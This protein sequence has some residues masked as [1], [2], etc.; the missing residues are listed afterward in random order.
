MTHQKA[1]GLANA[2]IVGA[3]L[4]VA[5][6]ILGLPFIIA[7]WTAEPLELNKF[8]WLTGWVLVATCCLAIRVLLGKKLF[9]PTP[10][11]LLGFGIWISALT[12]SAIS[13]W[14]IPASFLGYSTQEYTSVIGAVVFFLFFS[15]ITVAAKT[16]VGRRAIM[17]SII[18]SSGLV[19]LLA[20]LSILGVGIGI[21]GLPT[22][23]PTVTGIF[24]I[25]T[26]LFTL[27]YI[28]LQ[29]TSFAPV[30]EQ[31]D[32]RLITL[33]G[34]ASF[35]IA[36]PFYLA[37]D[38]TVVWVVAL[39]CS[40][41]ILAAGFKSQSIRS[42]S[43]RFI[44]IALLILMSVSML[45]ASPRFFAAL[46]LEVGPNAAASF[47]IAKATWAD[48]RLLFG[49][50]PGTFAL[51]FDLHH[52]AGLNQTDF[53]DARFDRGF[54]HVATLLTTLGILGTIAWGIFV[55]CIVLAHLH[56]GKDGSFPATPALIAFLGSVI[57]ACLYPQT[58]TLAAT[59]I[60]FAGLGTALAPGSAQE[61]EMKDTAAVGA[62]SLVGGSVAIIAVL[63]LSVFTLS[64][65][66][67]EM[68]Y[69]KALTREGEASYDEAILLLDKA[70]SRNRWNDAY[71]AALSRVLLTK[72]DV[73]ARDPLSDPQVVQ[74]LLGSS[75]NA[76]VKATDLAP[77]SAVRWAERGDLYRDIAGVVT[78]GAPFSLVSY[79]EAIKFSPVNPKYRVGIGRAQ[80][81][82][83]ESLRQ[84]SEAPGGEQFITLR[85]E[86]LEAADVAFS[87]AIKL[88]ADYIPALYFQAVTLDA[89]GL[90]NEAVVAMEKV[91]DAAPTDIG[92][93][94]NLAL[95]Y[96]RQERSDLAKIELE[97]ALEI[98]PT[99]ANARWYL[100]IIAEE[101]GDIAGAIKE[102]E[103][104]LADDPQNAAAKQRLERLNAPAP[105]ETETVA[106]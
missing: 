20:T 5:I 47:N 15:A 12:I 85:A 80:L 63:F 73:I 101:A 40:I 60:V 91:R 18:V 95:L 14:S 28:A 6:A 66:S 36:I 42:L 89:R 46:P 39:L 92:V 30:L 68:L 23:T 102:V 86:A 26:H 83:A 67:A 31:A 61:K 59:M 55:I 51:A 45:V 19:S 100:S 84:K 96:M 41:G 17:W 29:G 53:W 52:N 103:L 33:A 99:F 69:A 24:L 34:V 71:Y 76:A 65:Y 32:R 106:Q 11:A 37:L 9:L 97:K 21:Q 88:K 94:L 27:S 13:S 22:G 38:A 10:L 105:V 64:R 1:T 104:I 70:A 7:P 82:I 49:S 48:G 16:I 77:T 87:Q 93:R 72:A 43:V 58:L 56:R 98:A 78:D 81:A 2:L 44:P 8:V 79:E 3:G 74:S 4:A 75:I 25:L 57:A 50:G 35:V 62:A 54:S 90:V